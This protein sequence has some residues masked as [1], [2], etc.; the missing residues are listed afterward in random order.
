MMNVFDFASKQLDLIDIEKNSE[1]ERS[2]FVDLIYKF[3]YSIK[4]WEFLSKISIL[5]AIL[6][7]F[8]FGQFKKRKRKEN[9]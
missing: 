8:F 3:S 6:H 1:V 5:T 4:Q 2:K 9:S 7:S